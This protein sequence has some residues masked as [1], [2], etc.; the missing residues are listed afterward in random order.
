MNLSYRTW[1]ALLVLITLAASIFVIAFLQHYLHLDPCPL[2]I[3]QRIGLW[4]MGFFALMV[5][6]FNPKGTA[7]RVLLWLGGMAGTLW[8][9]G[10]AARHTYM[11]Y[12]PS[13]EPAQCGPG[14]NYWV[15][16]MP[17]RDVLRQVLT[18]NGDCSVIDWTLFGLSIPAQ[19]LI[20]FTVILLIQLLMLSKIIKKSA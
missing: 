4:V 7:M 2:C 3:F 9:L 20:L 15:E 6:L 14:L 17:L 5:A 18:G 19:S 10:V 12:F 1:H 11:L 16:T 8:G 13:A